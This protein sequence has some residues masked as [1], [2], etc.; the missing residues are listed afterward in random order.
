MSKLER[1]IT[2]IE[3]MDDCDLIRTHNTYC[4]N[5]D[6]PD[7]EIYLNDL[8]EVLYGLSPVEVAMKVTFGDWNPNHEYCWF[9]GYGNIVSGDGCTLINNQIFPSDIAR[10]AIDEDD[11][12][13]SDL[14]REILDEE[15]E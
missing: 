1:I 15:D 13:G 9:N 6:N 11:D 10:A 5:N 2:V 12:F 3:S 4:E 8:D 7:D 14:I